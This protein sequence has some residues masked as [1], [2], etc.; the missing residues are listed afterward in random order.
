MNALSIK[1]RDASAK[2]LDEVVVKKEFDVEEAVSSI[3][4]YANLAKHKGE[5]I[6]VEIW[7]PSTREELCSNSP[8]NLEG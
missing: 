3:R 6:V 2:R 1:M 8:S 5:T 7:Q 4:F